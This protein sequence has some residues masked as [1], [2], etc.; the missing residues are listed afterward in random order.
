MIDEFTTECLAID[1]AGSIRSG[2]VIEV[3]TQ[4]VS[5][6]GA[7]R[8]LRSDNGPGVRG[9]RDLALVADRQI[10]TAF[11]DPGKPWQNAD[12]SFNGKFRN[13]CLMVE[14][15]GNRREAQVGD[16]RWRRHYNDDRPHMSF[17]N[18]TQ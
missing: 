10:E 13:E 16:Q 1:V 8:Y 3:L 11:I 14:W 17:G 12:E 4:L 7:P 5:V 2:R 18:S 15:F 6:H 9:H